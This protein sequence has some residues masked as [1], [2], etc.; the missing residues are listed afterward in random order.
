MAGDLA[1]RL[2]GRAGFEDAH[3]SVRQRGKLA[4]KAPEGV[5]LVAAGDL[6]EDLRQVKDAGRAAA[7][8]GRRRAG[9]RGAGGGA[10]SRAWPGR[11]E[12][13][14]ALELGARMRES[15]AA[16]P[17]VPVDRGRRAPTARCP[18]PSRATWRS[19]RASWW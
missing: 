7:D 6:V 12:R 4:E 18:T 2:K 9:H 14:V 15:G 5:E 10:R 13:A 3:V 11:T 1:E 17:V 8:R 16:G 19:G